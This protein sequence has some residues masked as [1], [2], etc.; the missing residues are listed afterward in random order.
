MSFAQLSRGCINVNTVLPKS[1]RI[2]KELFKMTDQ[3][4][5]SFPTRKSIQRR[6]RGL[7]GSKN[8]C[9]ISEVNCNLYLAIR[10]KYDQLHFKADFNL[11]IK[12]GTRW[13][14]W[15]GAT[16]IYCWRQNSQTQFVGNKAVTLKPYFARPR[17]DWGRIDVC[18]SSLSLTVCSITSVKIN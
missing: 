17:R 6:S 11:E 4:H 7:G 14:G 1:Y 13:I 8:A 16:C 15:L 9:R 3:D 2:S 10:Q 12:S 18:T 5:W